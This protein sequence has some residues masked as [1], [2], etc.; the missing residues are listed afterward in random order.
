MSDEAVVKQIEGTI[1]EVSQK[2]GWTSFKINTG[3]QYMTKLDTKIDSIIAAAN[4][5][6]Q[7]TA[8]WTYNESDSETPNPH[9]PGKFFKNRRLEKVEIG[10]TITAP[11]STAGGTVRVSDETTRSSIE[12]QTIVKAAIP[13]WKDPLNDDQFFV[14][15]DKLAAWIADTPAASATAPIVPQPA[16][17]PDVDIPF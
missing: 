8:V 17:D 1:D 4:A 10:G 12:R 2:N 3:G 15:L 16:E 9:Q 14:F 5:V 11:A 13:A 7:Q 6:G